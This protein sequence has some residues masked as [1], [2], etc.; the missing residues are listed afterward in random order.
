MAGIGPAP[1]DPSK[2]ARRNATVA[3]TMLPAEG[4]KGRAPAWPLG[5]DVVIESQIFDAKRDIA[6]AKEEL[7]WASTAKDRAAQRRKLGRLSKKLGELEARKKHAATV[8]KKIWSELWKTPQA[9]QWEKRGWFR[10]VALYARH[11]AKAEAG[12][13][14]DSKEARQR[15]DRLG[16]NDMSMLR[17]RWAIADKAEPKKTTGPGKSTTSSRSRRGP[18]RAVPDI[19]TG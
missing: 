19:K 1:K 5:G 7:E 11:Q 17:L 9:T 8:E 13:L 14:D 4:R 16:L 6:G 12:S 15:E 18:L 10:E 2:R 3:M